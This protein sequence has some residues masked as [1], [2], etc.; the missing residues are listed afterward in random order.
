ML[1]VSV[2]LAQEPLSEVADVGR[3]ADPVWGSAE[4]RGGHAA[5]VEL[6]QRGIDGL[7]RV[8]AAPVGEVLLVVLG[9][10]VDHVS[11]VSL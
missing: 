10:A 5:R 11:D 7:L 9:P 1:P 3:V 4:V 6:V 2:D 8:L